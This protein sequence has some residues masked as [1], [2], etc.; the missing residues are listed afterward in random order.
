MLQA[1]AELL[2]LLAF[3]TIA[4]EVRG[5]TWC[6][7]AGVGRMREI[8]GDPLPAMAE[9][10]DPRIAEYANDQRRAA[11]I[12]AKHCRACPKKCSLRGADTVTAP[13]LRLATSRDEAET[14]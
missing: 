9:A 3:L 7:E 2:I 10:L 6:R 13:P 4:R 14:A 11:S 8:V 1:S 5:K 12:L